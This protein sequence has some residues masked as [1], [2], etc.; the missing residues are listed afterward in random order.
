MLISV[1]WSKWYVP[2]C[3]VPFS[4]RVR[5]VPRRAR[6]KC[7]IANVS[8]VDESGRGWGAEIHWGLLNG[9]Y[10]PVSVEFYPRGQNRG[11]VTHEA[12]RRFPLGSKIRE[13]QESMP[14]WS[15]GQ[16]TGRSSLVKKNASETRR[17]AS[18]LTGALH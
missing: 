4:D 9:R 15:Y 8:W 11:P 3:D 2:L 10:E 5:N 12:I 16:A 13:A 6:S 18:E 14:S 1:A 7:P 17:C